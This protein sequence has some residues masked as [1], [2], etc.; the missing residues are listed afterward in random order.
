MSEVK[1]VAAL[2]PL[3]CV[4]C[5]E[6]YDFM[7]TLKRLA[8]EG[9]RPVEGGQYCFDCTKEVSAAQISERAAQNIARMTTA[10]GR[11]SEGVM[12]EGYEKMVGQ[13]VDALK[14][15]EF[16]E[17][18]YTYD[19]AVLVMSILLLANTEL[20]KLRL[21]MERAALDEPNEYSTLFGRYEGLSAA[22]SGILS[23]LNDLNSDFC[24]HS[25]DK[26]VLHLMYDDDDD[27]ES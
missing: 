20:T 2:P 14:N 3:E 8:A 23:D 9:I 17:D 11:I 25:V 16:R 21:R 24:L 4:K 10:I 22:L 7:D 1:D 26:T 27:G 15:P 18:V 12:H 13:M 19:H 6:Q 5:G